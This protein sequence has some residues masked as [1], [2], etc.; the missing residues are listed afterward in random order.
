MHVK[1]SDEDLALRQ[2]LRD[3]FDEILTD[4]VRAGLHEEGEAGGPVRDEVMRR[5]GADGWFGIGWPEEYGGGTAVPVPSSS[6]TRRPTER[7]RRCRW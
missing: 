4:E 2:E 3:Y 6:S 5:I 7:R 1:L